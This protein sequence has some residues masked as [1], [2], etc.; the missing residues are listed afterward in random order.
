MIE[1]TEEQKEWLKSLHQACYMADHNVNI[2]GPLTNDDIFPYVSNIFDLNVPVGELGFESNNNKLLIYATE[3][4]DINY[5]IK[6]LSAFL[7]RFDLSQIITFTWAEICSTHRPLSFGGGAA[8]VSKS[9]SLLQ[10]TPTMMYCLKKE[11]ESRQK[12]E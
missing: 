12:L 11:L 2:A 7:K 10:D 3:N 1:A 8:A 6:I 5:T 9:D 4:G